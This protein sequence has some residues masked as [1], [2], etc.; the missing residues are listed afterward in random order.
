VICLVDTG[1][2]T[3]TSH[4]DLLSGL[5][6][7]GFSPSDLTYILLTH[8]H[9]DHY[10][11]LWKLRALTN[12][13]IGCHELDVQTVAHHEAAASL[14]ANRL[15]SFLSHAGLSGDEKESLLGM[16]Q[17]TKELYRSVPVDFTYNSIPNDLPA[18]G[19]IHLPGHCPGHVALRLNDVVLCG[20]MV[21]EG[22]TPH[23]AP[24][25]IQPWGGLDRYLESLD[26]LEY[27]AS[28]ARLVLNG[29]D[30]VI[31]DLP[32]EIDATRGNIVRRMS[33]AVSAL[34]EPRTIAEVCH[35]VYE[36]PGGYNLFLTLE[37]TGAYLE[38]LYDHA[39]IEITNPDELEQGSPAKYRSLR[40][41]ADD[42]LL[43]LKN[44]LVTE[45]AGR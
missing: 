15:A 5:N 18:F 9:I 32:A 3:E 26:K 28:G 44:K 17:I 35:V 29:H 19:I 16:Y 23:L 42:E 41:I 20:D 6:R 45:Q 12:A 24:S 34:A 10:G 33:R 40:E 38:Y 39:L 36:S 7:A 31:S 8:A 30:E 13:K 11:G 43:P 22:V 25:S 37:K 4:A 2:G 27:W 1:S 14:V 21:V